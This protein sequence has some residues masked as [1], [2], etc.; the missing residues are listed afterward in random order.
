MMRYR[1]INTVRS[2]ADPFF[3]D[4][5]M[6]TRLAAWYVSALGADVGKD[7]YIETIPLIET[8]LL[9]IGDGASI[10]AGALVVAHALEN[11][12]LDFLKVEV[13]ENAAI[14]QRSYV[15]P[16]ATIAKG[17]VVGALSLAMKGET[18]PEGTYAEGAPLVYVGDWDEAVAPSTPPPRP[19]L[20]DELLDILRKDSVLPDDIRQPPVT[21]ALGSAL[22]PATRGG[23]PQVVLLTGATGFVGSFLL[24][25]LLLPSRGVRLVY[26][27]VRAGSRKEAASR[28][29]HQ[30]LHH[31]L[32]TE[33][34]WDAHM[35]TRIIALPGD[36]AEPRLG[37][38]PELWA[39]LADEVDAVINNGALVNVTK[40]YEG[41]RAANVDAVLELLRLC[42]DGAAPTPLHQIST[43]GTLP[44]ASGSRLTE[45]YDSRGDPS[46]LVPSGY[47]QSK[48]VAEQLV[49][50]ASR[51]GLPTA[52]YR[53]G[54][55]GG[56]SISGGANE[57]DI[58]MLT[59]KGCLQLGAFPQ[60]Y[61]FPLNIIPGDWAAAVVVDR[62]MAGDLG[63]T[64]HVTNPC[65][66]P[67]QMAVNILRDMGYSFEEVPY[68]T[69]R[70]R[71]LVCASEDNALRPL[72]L[73]F[74]RLP[75]PLR[76]RR[77]VDFF[78][79]DCSNAGIF[80]N[81]LTKEQLRRDF[82][83][84][85]KVGFFPPLP[86]PSHRARQEDPLC[87]CCC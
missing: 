57:S 53:L 32:C 27:V 82:T 10:D 12:C 26:C 33:G 16:G 54:R 45:A 22:P 37:Q 68:A 66:P 78:N 5:M 48:W 79:V 52:L 71:L 29:R 13:A 2:L 34:E 19:R 41:L 7:V 24:R 50:E 56:D 60:C 49:F 43:Q 86:L 77:S 44:R 64:F 69:W 85:A 42:A 51:R 6:G 31:E 38:D 74:G 15:L 11:G 73:A 23:R 75:R 17:S 65:P 28:L 67:F 1:I 80:S 30:L 59:L 35:A 62:V 81:T 20:P 83:W 58:C 76:S 55:I 21:S 84:C 4:L 87:G 18:I 46:H 36:L 25:E 72:E 70:E 63:R 3:L 9:T 8:D 40:G 39:H 61:A 47:D 14:G